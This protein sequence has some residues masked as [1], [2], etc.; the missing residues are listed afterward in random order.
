[1]KALHGLGFCAGLVGMALGVAAP[2]AAAVEP[3]GKHVDFERYRDAG[4][5]VLSGE[6]LGCPEIVDEVTVTFD[7]SGL[8]KVTLRGKDRLPYYLDS[9]HGTETFSANGHTFTHEFNSVF[10]ALEVVDEGD[11][12]L[13][14]LQ[15]AGFDR[16]FLDGE[17][18]FLDT[19]MNR[20]QFRSDHAGTPSDPSDDPQDSFHFVGVVKESTGN[21][22][23]QDRDFCADLVE[24][25]ELEVR[26]DGGA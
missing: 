7:V 25:L 26:S 21:N 18:I 4:T 13:I 17:R 5:E 2:A 8:R 14:T 24:F 6:D 10:K 3:P 1:M 9:A 23:T 22:D 12:L 16:Y 19:G 15:G 11:T 20:V